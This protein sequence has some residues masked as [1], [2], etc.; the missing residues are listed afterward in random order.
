MDL[1]SDLLSQFVKVTKDDT[2]V[3]NESTVYGTVKRVGDKTYVQLDGSDLLTPVSTTADA[4][5]E[6][7]VTVMIKN[8]TA[9]I[10]GNLSSP[11]AS[12]KDLASTA[13][14]ISDFEIVMA[15]K[16]TA[17]DLEAVNATIESLR[18]KLG[19]IT[20]LESVYADIENLQAKFADLE[21]VNANDVKALNAT[22]E[23]LEATFGTFT[24]ISTEDL[25]ALNAYITTLKGYTADFT[26]V[27]AEVLE[28]VKA[29]IKT[30]VVKKLDVNFAN[31]DFANVDKATFGEFYAES[32]IIEDYVAKDGEVTGTLV[33]VSI[34]ADNINAGSLSVERLMLQGRD[35]LFYKLNVNAMGQTT[36]EQ[37]PSDE[38]EKLK[39]GIHGKSIIAESITADKISVSDLVA[40][41][42]K[43]GG[44]NISNHSLYS[45]VV[46]NDGNVK[47]K[48]SVDSATRGIHMSDD[49]QFAIGDMYNYLRFYKVVD[50]DGN[51]VLDEDGN[52][53]FKLDISADS[54]TFGSNSKSSAAD[55][56][57]LTEHVKIGTVVDETTSD[58]K[59]CVELSEGD[60]DF[61]QI[62]TNTETRFVD[63]TTIKTKINTDGVHSDNVTVEA[64]LRQTNPAV[65]GQ[66]IWAVRPNGNYG[67]IW[68]E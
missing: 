65:S 27:S 60:S 68:K 30:L 48:E 12:S 50:G 62:I 9:T 8:H 17:E 7:R 6:E 32:G 22:I 25:E 21:Y 63:G 44:F 39:N 55:L 15:Y 24:D 18:V 66:W 42:A 37:L 3:Q 31:I 38:Q 61:K 13:K 23:N 46:D 52:P 47:Y 51:P 54:I 29:E 2:K 58:E 56:K 35:G 16:V 33:A 45:G 28:A 14:E 43:I 10:T 40:F 19:Q 67:L 59:P 26:Y 20:S 34:N 49:G 64:E 57:A 41:G 11:S 53:T 5:D 1:S 36:A 4:K